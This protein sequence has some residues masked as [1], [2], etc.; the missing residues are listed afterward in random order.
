MLTLMDEA[1]VDRAVVVPPIW[2]TDDNQS[3]ME[4]TVQYPGRFG[5][6]GRFDL[7]DSNRD[8][9]E[10]WLQQPGMLGI[11]MSYPK[12]RGYAWLDDVDAFPWFWSACERL[13]IPVMLLFQGH[14]GRIAPIAERHPNLRLIVD[15][16]ALNYIS[17]TDS[18]PRLDED[19]PAFVGFQEMLALARY[20]HIYGKLT[21]L[22]TYT[23]EQYPFPRLTPY[24]EQ[25][26]GAFG[27]ERLMWGTDYSRIRNTTYQECLDHVRG[28]DFLSESDKEW[29]LGKAVV[30]ALNWTL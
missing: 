14:A 24:L 15:H 23:H 10:T 12:D 2:A 5:I 17:R 13:N 19:L 26:Y 6:M 29:I 25:A 22:P 9:I 3:A 8:R 20:P 21:S 4:W 27:P 30:Q 7:W 16:M 1:G 18:P 11:R 28:L